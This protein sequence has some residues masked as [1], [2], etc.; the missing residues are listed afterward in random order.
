MAT[1]DPVIGKLSIAPGGTG[2]IKAATG[3]TWMLTVIA[4]SGAASIYY[5]DGTDDV[6]IDS[7]TGPTAW[8]RY[9][10]IV[11][12]TIFIRV[13]DD[14]GAGLTVYYAGVKL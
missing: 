3:E 14:S 9:N 13:K 12:D 10:F 4:V 11:S 5:S 7:S 6:L 1:G 8:A 2:D